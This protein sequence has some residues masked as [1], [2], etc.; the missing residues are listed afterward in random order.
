V[1]GREEE[2]EHHGGI[3]RHVTEAFDSLARVWT[4]GAAIRPVPSYA[5]VGE[6]ALRSVEAALAEEATR[7]ASSMD[8]AFERFEETQPELAARIQEVLERPLDET[9]LALGYFLSIAV[10]LAFETVF[11]G[12]LTEV[13][14]DAWHA[15][16]DALALEEDLRSRGADEPLDLDGVLALEQPGV[17]AFVHEHIEAA[18]STG[19]SFS[20]DANLGADD[21]GDGEE[22]PTGASELAADDVRL[23][24]RT[25]LLETLAL[26]HAVTPGENPPADA[27]PELR[28]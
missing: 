9:A 12:R 5:V 3:R 11:T 26:S 25:I 7:G 24:Y 14:G 22:R 21:A 8:T 17:V 15:T 4:R 19:H 10:W 27:A 2:A 18:L 23:V 13:T 16:V 20:D 6:A 28:A 1:V